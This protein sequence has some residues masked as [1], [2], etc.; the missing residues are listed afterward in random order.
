M[1]EHRLEVADVFQAY[2]KEFLQRWGHV[3]SQQQR[4]TLRDIGLCRT[5]A[6]GGHLE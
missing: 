5:A 6:L 3:L 1:R 4:K 2:Q